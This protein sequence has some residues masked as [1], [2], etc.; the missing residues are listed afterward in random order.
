MTVKQLE[1]ELKQER[2]LTETM[3][4]DMVRENFAICLFKIYE[5]IRITP[6]RCSQSCY[7]IWMNV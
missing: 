3:V 5:N 1:V 7:Y 6:S 2:S 4:A